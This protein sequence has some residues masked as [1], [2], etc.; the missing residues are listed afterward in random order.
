MAR[1][2]PRWKTL[3]NILAPEKLHL[4]GAA[5]ALL[6]TSSGTL[7]F[8]YFTGKLMDGFAQSS[9]SPEIWLAVVNNNTAMY[10]DLIHKETFLQ[11]L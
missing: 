8:P 11:S 4:S 3:V 2:F 9:T 5:V 6:F 10:F 7:S 1:D